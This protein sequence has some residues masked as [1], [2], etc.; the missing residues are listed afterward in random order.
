MFIDTKQ[1]KEILFS[2]PHK[3]SLDEVFIEFLKNPFENIKNKLKQNNK[4][5]Y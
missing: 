5:N 1:L 2:L 4:K 3:I